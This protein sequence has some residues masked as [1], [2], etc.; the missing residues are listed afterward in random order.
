MYI[1]TN[2]FFPSVKY[3]TPLLGTFTFI[4]QLGG[5]DHLNKTRSQV[6]ARD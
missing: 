2:G 1:Y 3:W 4:Y 6:G 5:F